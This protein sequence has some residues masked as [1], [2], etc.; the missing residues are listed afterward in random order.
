MQTDKTPFCPISENVRTA[1]DELAKQTH[2]AI[3]NVLVV[4]DLVGKLGWIAGQVETL[5]RRIAEMEDDQ[6]KATL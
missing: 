6:T 5:E 2:T 4:R 1:R 3:P